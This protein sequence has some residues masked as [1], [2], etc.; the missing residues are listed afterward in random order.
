[1]QWQ[2]RGKRQ[3]KNYGKII[4]QFSCQDIERILQAILLGVL[5]ILVV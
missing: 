4:A 2:R 1:M 3:K 5:V